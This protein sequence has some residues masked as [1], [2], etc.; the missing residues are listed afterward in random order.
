METNNE[1]NSENNDDDNNECP[2]CFENYD[3]DEKL[4]KKV[5]CCKKIICLEC[6]DKIYKKNAND[7]KCCFCKQDIKKSPINLNNAHI[8][9]K[10]KTGKELECLICKNKEDFINFFYDEDEKKIKC[11]KCFKNK[12]KKKFRLINIFKEFNKN[13][14]QEIEFFKKIIAFIEKKKKT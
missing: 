9:K 3:L 13:N 14:Q 7:F 1:N 6:L 4:P 12:S 5:P 11:K 8:L 10:I 2:I